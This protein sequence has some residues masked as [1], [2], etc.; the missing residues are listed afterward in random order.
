MAFKF[1]RLW[2]LLRISTALLVQITVTVEAAEISR[3]GITNKANPFGL[4]ENHIELLPYQDISL[5]GTIER[6]DLDKVK[7]VLSGTG[8]SNHA[9][10]LLSSSGGNFFEAVAIALF[11]QEKYAATYIPANSRCLSACAIV[12]M[13]GSQHNGD[14]NLLVHR[15]MHAT[16]TLGFHAPFISGKLPETVPGQL[17]TK[18]Y[19]EALKTASEFLRVA[20][21]IDWPNSLTLELLKIPQTDFLYVDTVG[22]AGRWGIDL[23]GVTELGPLDR[24]SAFQM[25]RN[26]LDW[27]FERQTTNRFN[28]D[29]VSDDYFQIARQADEIVEF[30]YPNEFGTSCKITVDRKAIYAELDKG[31]LFYRPGRWWHSRKPETKIS[32]LKNDAESAKERIQFSEFVTKGK[33]DDFFMHNGSRMKFSY[34]LTGGGTSLVITYDNPRPGMRA[35][36]VSPGTVLFSG[37]NQGGINVF[38]T[39]RIFRKGCRPVE[40][41]VGGQV[42]PGEK[43][44]VIL[45]G[46]GKRWL[47]RSC[48]AR[49]QKGYGR[50]SGRLTFNPITD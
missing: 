9:R 38:G 32:T 5:T 20:S 3:L 42:E 12:F 22:R 35:E 8:G 28:R 11:I 7:T 45:M 34:E 23:A 4:V 47:G 26:V 10:F 27:N 40:Y 1:S 31:Q 46:V 2:T 37:K 14:G 19:K 50:G 29:G 30:N 33:R 18:V 48:K 36:G 15:T 39:A 44:T 16:A 13:A 6:G 43:K 21:T 17:I 24:H 25:C 41:D 49:E